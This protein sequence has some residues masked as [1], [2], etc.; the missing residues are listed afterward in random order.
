MS[1]API[2]AVFIQHRDMGSDHRLY[3]IS[4]HLVTTP[5]MHVDD[6]RSTDGHALHIMCLSHLAGTCASRTHRA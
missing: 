1:R 6:A 5:A 3:V 2:A 4:I